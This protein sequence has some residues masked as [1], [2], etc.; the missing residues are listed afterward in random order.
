MKG[1]VTAV[2]FSPTHGSE[3]ITC[4]IAEELAEKLASA[5]Q[6]INL[7]PPENRGKEHTFIEEELL[8]FGFPVYGGRIPAVLE[9]SIRKLK[10]NQTPAVLIATYGNREYEDALVEAADLLKENGFLIVAA[11]AF[12]AEHSMTKKVAAARPDQEDLKKADS[13]ASLIYEKIQEGDLHEP[14]IK[15]N[16]PYKKRS[17]AVPIAPKTDDSCTECMACVQRCPMHAIQ[18]GNPKSIDA[19]LCIRCCACIK[20][21]PVHA[22]FFDDPNVLKI[23]S[24]LE[25]K[26]TARKEPE[27]FLS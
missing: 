13:F 5:Y 11:G 24:M 20:T 18:V 1:T 2:Y 15:G 21:C 27:W 17:P 22:K 3:K 25:T 4:R 16:R 7:T 23:I 19:N 26:C 12:L 6:E 8:V 9:D 14:Q 10:G